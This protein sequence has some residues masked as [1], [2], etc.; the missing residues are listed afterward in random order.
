MEDEKNKLK[1][2]ERNCKAARKTNINKNGFHGSKR[3]IVL[4]SVGK[5]TFKNVVITFILGKEI[6]KQNTHYPCLAIIIVDIIIRMDKK[7]TLK[8][9]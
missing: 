5:K 4:D 1:E 7:S 9:I 3:P 8:Y 2:Y 6:P